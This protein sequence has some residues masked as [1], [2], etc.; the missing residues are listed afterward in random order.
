MPPSKRKRAVAPD[1][2]PD[3]DDDEQPSQS[4]PAG[5]GA[6]SQ[7]VQPLGRDETLKLGQELARWVVLREHA[8]KP[9]ARTDMRDAILPGRED[10]GGKILKSVVDA[11]NDVLEGTFGLRLAFAADVIPADEAA[12]DDGGGGASQAAA[13]S[14]TQSQAPT[15]A[16]GK[17]KDKSQPKYFL[18]NTLRKDAVVYEASEA[19]K[20]YHALVLVVQQL[21]E[22]N[23]GAMEEDV[24]IGAWLPKLGYRSHDT[25][26]KNEHTTFVNIITKDMV[27]D[28]YLRSRKKQ[29]S[30]ETEFVLGARSLH[31]KDANAE[32]EFVQGR[33]MEQAGAS[34]VTQSQA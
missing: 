3:D 14:A 26:P 1:P 9:I 10:K 29:G 34:Q 30:G 16:G 22:H 27:K 33:V 11:A 12:A 15:Q 20:V 4:Q 5:G 28:G 32:K 2:E 25:V 31:T 19:Q 17:K 6:A 18:V 7:A 8:R 13:A 23:E 21:I 24:L